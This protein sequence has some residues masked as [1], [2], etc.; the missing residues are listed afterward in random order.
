[1]GNKITKI[2]IPLINVEKIKVVM[3]LPL[4]NEETTIKIIIA[5]RS[6]T[7]KNPIEILPN[8]L[9]RE[10]L[11]ESSFIIIIVEENVSAI[12]IYNAVVGENPSK[13]PIKY[14]I[15]D[16]K[17]TCPIPV[18]KEILPTSLIVLGFKYNP[19]I[20]KRKAIPN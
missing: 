11:S 6:W 14:P 18:I 13:I 20:N 19:T 3:L 10:S 17:I 5:I 9:S 16:V 7:S 2:M 4:D 12:A 15:N 1:M 8:N